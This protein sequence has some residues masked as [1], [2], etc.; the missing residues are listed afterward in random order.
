MAHSNAWSDAPLVIGDQAGQGFANINT[1]HDDVSDREQLEHHWANSAADGNSGKNTDGMHKPGQVAAVENQSTKA[2]IEAGAGDFS[3]ATNG[4]I[5]I[6]TITETPYVKVGTENAT[7]G[8]WTK[9]HQDFG[10]WANVTVDASPTAT[11]AGFLVVT[12]TVAAVENICVAV[13][14]TPAGSVTRAY[15]MAAW[16]SEAGAGGETTRAASFTMP[17]KNGATYKVAKSNEL[18]S[19]TVTAY[20]IP[21]V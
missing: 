13:G 8:T 4:S 11:T 6:S 10:D 12:V 17:V 21:L 20:F 15:A 3:T 18:G 16:R 7:G 9:V 19:G 2:A 5:A 14:T 1:T